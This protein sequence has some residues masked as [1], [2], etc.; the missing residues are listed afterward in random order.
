M[1]LNQYLI[2]GFDFQFLSGT[3]LSALVVIYRNADGY[4]YRAST[5]DASH[6][7]RVIGITINSVIQ[8]T[9]PEII[10]RGRMLDNSWSWDVTKPI[11]F[12]A[13]GILTQ[14]VPTFP[15]AVYSLIVAFA[16]SPN[17]LFVD[18]KHPIYLA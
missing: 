4:I 5:A 18:I 12:D 3:P 10:T 7:N 16:L 1:I 6:G 8:Y 9:A 15:T 11:F 2:K 14:S 17:S 13:N